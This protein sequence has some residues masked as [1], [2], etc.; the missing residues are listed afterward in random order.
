MRLSG[1]GDSITKI[2]TGS[3]TPPEGNT[4]VGEVGGVK[5]GT[6]LTTIVGV[7]LKQLNGSVYMGRGQWIINNNV[8]QRYLCNAGRQLVNG[9][10][11]FR[12]W[13]GVLPVLLVTACAAWWICLMQSV[14]VWVA[15]RVNGWLTKY[16]N[17]LCQNHESWS[18]DRS[19][20]S[21]ALRVCG[22][23]VTLQARW[24]YPW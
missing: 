16:L 10:L 22:H 11:H 23:F 13:K 4:E 24:D 5:E 19:H 12:N 20:Y 21:P 17:T 18:M 8:I 9:L 1:Y 2:T 14:F 3:H 15:D 7:K 6:A